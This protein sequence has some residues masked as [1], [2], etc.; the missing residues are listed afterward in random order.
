MPSVRCWICDRYFPFDPAM[1]TV[2]VD[3]IQGEPPDPA[4]AA[5]VARARRQ[6]VCYRCAKATAEMRAADGLPDLWDGQWGTPPQK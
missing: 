6:Y 1:A 2:Q 3:P 5:A 4:D